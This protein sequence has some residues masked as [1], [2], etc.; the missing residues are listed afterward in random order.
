MVSRKSSLFLNRIFTPE[1]SW[2]LGRLIQCIFALWLINTVHI[3]DYAGQNSAYFNSGRSKQYT[4]VS[5]YNFAE[6]K[7][8][9]CNKFC[10]KKCVKHEKCINSD[11]FWGKRNIFAQIHGR[12]IRPVRP[13]SGFGCKLFYSG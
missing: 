9:N 2:S 8:V 4:F 1:S 13:E 6:K 10:M 12:G 5:Q 11:K 3:W 7:S